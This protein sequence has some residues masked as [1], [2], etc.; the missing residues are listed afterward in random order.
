MKRK[1]VDI[2]SPSMVLEVKSKRRQ[3]RRTEKEW[4][5]AIIDAQIQ[6]SSYLN[7]HFNE[8]RRERERGL[9]SNNETRR[10][11]AERDYQKY[12]DIAEM[13]IAGNPQLRGA[14]YNR[15][16]KEVQ[17]ELRR[18]GKGVVSARTIW[19]ALRPKNKV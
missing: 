17:A 10:R 14:T 3:R 4:I 12:R 5:E 18:R 8:Q 16:A 13:L 6:S 2:A 19:E 7:H 1:R 11:K 15:L 9:R